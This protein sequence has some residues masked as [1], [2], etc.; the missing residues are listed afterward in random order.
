[1]PRSRR[2]EAP[3]HR[4]CPSLFARWP[5]PHPDE[6]GSK[7]RRGTVLVVGGAPQ[8][9]GAVILAATAA[10]R[11]GAGKLQ[12]A[13]CRTIAALVATEVPEAYVVSLPEAKSGAV[14]RR[15][16]DAIVQHAGDAE[17]IL[18]GPGMMGEDGIARWLPAVVRRVA[19]AGATLVLDAAA[20]ALLRD[21][22]GGLRPLD[23][24]SVITPHPGEMAM[25]TGMAKADVLRAPDAVARR[26]AASSGA[27]VALK[28]AV[29]FIAAPDGE[30]FRNDAGNVGLATSGS[31]DTLAG[32]VVGL[33]AR[34]ATPL[35]SAAWA[36]HMHACAGDR[37]AAR[38]GGPLG[39]LA[40][41]LLAELPG[42]MAQLGARRRRPAKARKL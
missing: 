40:R 21:R 13:T 5:L 14:G 15:A 38:F 32:I 6:G 20:L 27:V 18:I 3:A 26:V 35:Q 25:I 12:I 34:G 22:P 37:L 16:I 17:A 29:T 39:F 10:L 30:L 42:V 24:R 4:L 23:G 19:R 7:E 31:G 41:E 8:T 28:G 11:A 9:P 1:M 2:A 36:V 33:S